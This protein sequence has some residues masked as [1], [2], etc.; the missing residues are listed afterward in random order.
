MKKLFTLF[1]ILAVCLVHTDTFSQ[2]RKNILVEDFET[3]PLENWTLVHPEDAGFT[4]GDD[5]PYSGKTY[6]FHSDNDKVACDDWCISPKVQLTKGCVLT[7]KERNYYTMTGYYQHHGVY[8]STTGND[9]KTDDFKL[10]LELDK[11]QDDWKEVSI[12]LHE[13][14]DQAV[15]IAF[16]YEGKDKDEWSIDDLK[17]FQKVEKDLQLGDIKVQGFPIEGKEMTYSTTISN[18]G[19]L[20]VSDIE[21]QFNS[22]TQNFT[23]IISLAADESKDLEFTSLVS[24]GENTI[25]INVV[26]ADD[27]DQD[28]NT[29]TYEFN[30]IKDPLYGF[31]NAANPTLPQTF[32][33]LDKQDPSKQFVYGDEDLDDVR[34]MAFIDGV[35]YISRNK[36]KENEVVGKDFGRMNFR[37]GEYEKISDINILFTA[38]AYNPFDEKLYAIGYGE[39]DVNMSLYSVNEANGEATKIGTNSSETIICTFAIDNKG[40]AFG[41]SLNDGKLQ[42]IDLTDFSL[43]EIGETGLTPSTAQSM[44]YSFDD[45]KLYWAYV[46]TVNGMSAALYEVNTETAEVNKIA[47]RHTA[48]IMGLCSPYSN[49]TEVGKDF[50]EGFNSWPLTNWTLES[51]NAEDKS[52][53]L[54]TDVKHM[55]EA[56]VC[57]LSN[58]I[59]S[60]TD[61]YEDYLISPQ[62]LLRKDDKLVF[63][64]LNKEMDKYKEHKILISTGSNIIEDGDFVEFQELSES[65]NEEWVKRTF[66]LDE[67]ANKKVYFAFKYS[68]NKASQWYIDQ[69]IT[70]NKDAIDVAVEECNIEDKVYTTGASLTP[71]FVVYNHGFEALKDIKAQLTINDN[72]FFMSIDLAVDEKKTI[73]FDAVQLTNGDIQYSFELTIDGDTNEENNNLSGTIK[74]LDNIDDTAYGYLIFSDKNAIHKGPVTYNILEPKKI[75]PMEK[76]TVNNEYPFAGAMIHH[77]WFCNYQKN[78]GKKNNPYTWELID[79]KKGKRLYAG[80]SDIIFREMSYN[81]KT[82]VLYGIT[83]NKLYS[84]NCKTNEYKLI[85]NSNLKFFAFA[86]D[87][88]G[89]AYGIA[90]DKNLYS[91]DLSNFNITLI[92]STKVKNIEY[93]QSMSFHHKTGNL[94]WNLCSQTKGAVYLVDTKTGKATLVDQLQ[95]NAQITSFDFPYGEERFYL[96]FLV[97][98]EGNS[99]IPMAIVR[100]EN[101]MKYVNE[102]GYITFFPFTKNKEISYYCEGQETGNGGTITIT[103]NHFIQV[104]LT[105]IEDLSIESS[106]YPNPCSTGIVHLKNED[107]KSVSI[108]DIHGKRVL[109]QTMKQAE[110]TIDVRTLTKGI[111]FIRVNQAQKASSNKLIIQ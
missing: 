41:I 78:D 43:T 1:F 81:Y 92:G 27:E 44:T 45:D 10:L 100:I 98:N 105:G 51:G 90:A 108:F 74:V 7:F 82:E 69:M 63:Y 76:A 84:I 15:Y 62:I 23:E 73:E 111:Y 72:S 29:S 49:I 67:Y 38:F 26:Y 60:D 66:Q 85:G 96:D 37:T 107:I 19:I 53:S 59:D 102:K 36:P 71:S 28:N 34:A 9:P 24:D 16:K 94:F 39:N 5:S 80:E 20:D 21:V 87:L 64:E 93:V 83:E 58:D 103:K 70:T 104:I 42:S 79:L 50:E 75:T 99:P 33:A 13:Y 88:E 18:V 48:I 89:N 35:L 46:T 22:N 14:T 110:N 52:W 40:D 6:L 47:D 30:A 31:V 8:I 55:G 65:T 12:D 86:I 32:I 25:T 68:G 54:S 61:V 4:Q 91:I 97:T 17:I 77:L 3:F 56:S 57:H 101:S 11:Q 109:H 106:I 2:S 95:H